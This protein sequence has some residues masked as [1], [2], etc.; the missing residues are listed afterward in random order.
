MKNK[1]NILTDENN[2]LK[3]ELIKADK[4]ITNFNN[5]YQQDVIFNL[6]EIIKNKNKEINDLKIEL[7]G[8]KKRLINFEDIITIQFISSENKINCPIICLKTDTFAEAEERL[9]RKYEEYRETNNNFSLNGKLI[10]KFKKICE[11]NIQD[12]DQIQLL[13]AN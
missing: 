8:N 11:N 3:N 6:N 10:L 4:I 7:Q 9:Y 13:D 5:N 1:I 2:K 12:G